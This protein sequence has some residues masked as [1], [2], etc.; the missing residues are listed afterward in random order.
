MAHAAWENL[1]LSSDA[2]AFITQMD[3]LTE[4]HGAGQA[5]SA[6]IL[7]N[8]AGI[9]IGDFKLLQIGISLE[10]GTHA[11]KEQMER[12]RVIGDCGRDNGSAV[13]HIA[14]ALALHAETDKTMP[15]QLCQKRAG[16]TA[17]LPCK[18]HVPA[19]SHA[20]MHNIA[21]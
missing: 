19:R 9:L 15:C 11:L 17:D 4:I 1:P 3:E 12:L 14:V 10:T 6:G 20:R 16:Y 13:L 21:S 18:K 8:I 2:Q 7:Q 5:G